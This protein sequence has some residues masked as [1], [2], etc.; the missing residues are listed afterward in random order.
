METAHNLEQVWSN[1]R[2]GGLRDFSVPAANIQ[3]DERYH[4][5]KTFRSDLQISNRKMLS[6]TW[7]KVKKKYISPPRT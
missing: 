6:F 5:S 7:E 4:R 2:S 3:I 1:L